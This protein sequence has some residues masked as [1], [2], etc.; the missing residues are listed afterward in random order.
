[1][2][3]T[4]PEITKLADALLQ[5][6][7]TVRAVKRDGKNPHFNS[8]YATLENVL[9]AA[10]PVLNAN[11]IIL[12]QAAGE[13]LEGAV[14][15]TT[16]LMH[17]S[18]EFMQSTLHV[19]LGKRDPQGVGSAIT[20]GLRYSLMAMLGLPPTDDDDGE[21]AMDRAGEYAKPLKSSAAMKR[22]DFWGEFETEI[23]ECMTLAALEQRKAYWR[24]R[25]VDD[26]WPVAWKSAAKD[27][28]EGAEKRIMD[29]IETE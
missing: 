19:P 24:K 5:F 28:F 10:K 15:V 23:D 17:T 12:T 18:G 16:R 9:D 6:Q 8:K 25:A 26:G 21:M 13:I 22:D 14:C 4:S 27:R 7:S 1:M 20:Y 2:I 29:E 3:E 11:G